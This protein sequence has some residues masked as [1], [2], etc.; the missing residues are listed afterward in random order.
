MEKKRIRQSA[1]LI[2]AVIAIIIFVIVAGKIINKYTP[3]KEVKDLYE[4][5]NLTDRSK[6]AI[7][8][9]HEVI[10]QQAVLKNG[11]AYIDY[12]T[13]KELFNSRFY[14]D[15]N[16]NLLLYTTA[17]DVISASASEK[18]YYI[19]KEK[20]T[21]NYEIVYADAE[22]AY[23]AIDYIKKF[24]DIDYRFY[25]DP[26]R[27]VVTSD[28]SD[29]TFVSVK[30][31]TQIRLKGGIKSPIL[32]EA[33]K[34]TGLFLL[35]GGDDWDKV[36]TEDGIIGYIQKKKLGDEER[37]KYKHSFEKEEFSH[38]LKDE[39]IN[40]A[41]HQVTTQDANNTVANVISSTKGLNVISPTWFYLNDNNG[42]LMNLASK[43][44]VD[45]CHSQG[46]E[47]WALVSNL[48]NKEVNST[49]VL[50]H[51][52]KR[53]NMV[54][55]LIAAAIQYNFD[56]INVDF[57]SLDAQAGEGYIQF[58]R[59]LSL[60]CENNGIVLSV[61]N[62][63]PTEYT[64]FYN[65]SEQANFADYVI[66]MGYDEHYVGSDEGSVA[67]IGFVK[68][69]IED[70]LKEVPANQTILA[71]PFYTR[72]WIET[73]KE[74][75]DDV[76]AA[77]DDYIPYDLTSQTSNMR[78]A[79]NMVSV[80]GVEAIWSEEDGQYYAEYENSGITYKIWLEDIKSM[81][82]RLEEASRQNLA[83]MSFWKLGLEDPAI[84]N[85]IIKYMN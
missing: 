81:E 66:I 22:T 42:G 55:E 18:D 49:E 80:N 26:N 41:W 16:E 8:L 37:K 33:A 5:Y 74:A 68:K 54:N 35:E 45:Y 34:E 31:D 63:V 69:G 25:E 10:S 23:I 15:T 3:S 20:K 78:E 40:M 73:P 56:G 84:W 52:S 2:A 61:D 64:A 51:T 24:T 83:G 1:I 43:E 9:D 76:E 36:A 65:R 6:A 60:K 30:K 11:M 17:K 29:V 67:S 19:T 48:E 57:E 62:Y 82:L 12:E 71:A 4:Y 28:W 46:I 47:V 58:I 59:E 53:T 38:I 77:S 14:W 32:T 75:A 44:Y 79:W 50:T 85:T 27:I 7:I 72:I 70:T 21:E 39:K 13:V